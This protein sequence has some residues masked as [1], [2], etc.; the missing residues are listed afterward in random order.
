MTNSEEAVEA[1]ADFLLQRD[2]PTEGRRMSSQKYEYRVIAAAILNGEAWAI[3]KAWPEAV[4]EIVAAL[5]DHR[6]CPECGRLGRHE[7]HAPRS[8]ISSPAA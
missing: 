1:L 6:V 3:R 4:N 7:D 8:S 5:D 2:W